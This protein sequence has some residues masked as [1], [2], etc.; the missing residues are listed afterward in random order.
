MNPS[1]CGDYGNLFPLQVHQIAPPGIQA[2]MLGWTLTLCAVLLSYC[3]YRYIKFK[4][5]VLLGTIGAGFF[6]F[7]NE[8]NLEVLVHVTQ[9]ANGAFPVYYA[10]G[11]PVPLFELTGYLCVFPLTCY[12]GYRWMIKGLSTKGMWIL[13]L[14]ICIAD[15]AM[16]IPANSQGLYVYQDPQL[17]KV[18]GFPLWN[19]WINS[20]AWVMGGVLIYF[21]EPYTRGWKRWILS[22]MPAIGMAFSWGFIDVPIVCALN[23]KFGPTGQIPMP[24]WGMWA[25]HILS[26]AFAILI[27]YPMIAIVAIDSKHR[28]KLP[29]LLASEKAPALKAPKEA[30]GK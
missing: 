19:C 8:A 28:L 11:M 7:F 25:L 21:F 12:I 5:S 3:F 22:F 6:A 17:L 16:E 2:W 24:M 18:G 13:F 27:M 9:S 1:G 29:E 15:C 26:F 23:M 14:V 10:Y 4:D 30:S 20:T